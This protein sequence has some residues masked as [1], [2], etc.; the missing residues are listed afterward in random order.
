MLW[1][2]TKRVVRTGFINFWRNSFVSLASVLVMTI[3]LGVIGSIIFT[4]VLLN[5]ALIQIKD[6]VDVNVYFVTTADEGD[7]TSIQKSLEALPEVQ[8]TIYSSREQVL[9]EFKKRHE[10]DNYTLQALE[11]LQEN[12]LG[13]ILNIKAKDPSQYAGIVKFLQSKSVSQRDGLPIIDKVNFNQNKTAIDKLTRIIKAGEQLGFFLMIAFIVISVMITFN[14]IRLAIYISR[15]E[16]SVMRLV[17]ASSKYVRGPFV[18]IGTMY[19]V[20]SAIIATLLFFPATYYLGRATG[21]FFTEVNIYHY[22]ITNFGY[23]FLLLL[24]A[25]VII[26]AVSSFLAVRRYLTV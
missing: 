23:I 10:N 7:I 19:G 6:K 11:E 1:T 9:T 14:T 24:G 15:E 13:A 21:D 5:T 17:G 16:I 2:N 3:T 4:S 12:P 20:F 22:Y 26:G 25:G 8:K 18:V